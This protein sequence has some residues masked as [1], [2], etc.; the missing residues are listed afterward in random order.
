MLTEDVA[1]VTF[2]AV[3]ALAFESSATLTWLNSKNTHFSRTDLL[4]TS[5]AQ[6]LLR[7]GCSGG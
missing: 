6:S 2:A 3:Q 1:I 4:G 5:H 7:V